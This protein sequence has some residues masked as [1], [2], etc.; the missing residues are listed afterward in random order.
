MRPRW[1]TGIGT[2]G[3]HAEREGMCDIAGFSAVRRRTHVPLIDHGGEC[4]VVELEARG[5]C[6]PDEP[7]D[8]VGIMEVFLQF[9]T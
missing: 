1:V 2:K 6:L 3:H 4:S 7:G 8:P 5:L 9:F